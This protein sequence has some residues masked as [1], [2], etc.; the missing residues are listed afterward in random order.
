MF[1]RILY[2][3]YCRKQILISVVTD[4]NVVQNKLLCYTTYVWIIIFWNNNMKN[5]SKMVTN[6]IIESQLSWSQVSEFPG[7]N[8][9]LFTRNSIIT[10]S[11]SHQHYF[12]RLAFFSRRL[13]HQ[14]LEE[15]VYSFCNCDAAFS[16]CC[17]FE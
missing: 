15:V 16:M 7:G 14:T 11:K 10:I 12:T 1:L 9:N 13:F 17:R 4:F 6:W 5:N 8:S 2:F 3:F